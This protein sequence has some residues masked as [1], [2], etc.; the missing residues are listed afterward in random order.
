MFRTKYSE[1]KIVESNPGDAIKD[2]YIGKYDIKGNLEIEPTGEKI[3]IYDEIQSH[4][5][6]C[7]INLIVKRFAAGDTDALARAQ[8]LYGDFSNMPKTY[9]DM[10]NTVIAG[11]AFFDALPVDVKAKFGNNFAQFMSEM[12]S[13]VWSEKMGFAQREAAAD[14]IKPAAP[15]ASSEGVIENADA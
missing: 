10:L 5:D 14:V 7:D 11:E 12:D 4:A 2:V 3:N 9:I 15:A 8:G 6:S 1:R 13:P